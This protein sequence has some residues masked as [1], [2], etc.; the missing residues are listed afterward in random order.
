MPE[1]KSTKKPSQK[2]QIS[3]LTFDDFLSIIDIL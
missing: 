3:W 1:L 2:S